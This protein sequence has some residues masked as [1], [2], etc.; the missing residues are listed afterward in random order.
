MKRLSFILIALVAMI[1]TA[2]NDDPKLTF[3]DYSGTYSLNDDRTLEITLDGFSLTEKGSKTEFNWNQGSLATLTLHQT[4]PGMGTVTIGGIVVTPLDNGSGISFEGEF[5][6]SET[7]KIVFKGTIINL[8]M[9][10]DMQTMP[11]T[12]AS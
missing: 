8:K 12:P 1:M 4:I 2:C 9:T 11:I 7:E 3:Y 5:A 6:K 10:L